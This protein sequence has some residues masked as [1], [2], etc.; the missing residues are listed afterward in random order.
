MSKIY[1]S[2][3]ESVTNWVEF[4]KTDIESLRNEYNI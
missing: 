4:I 1:K 2:D 3:E